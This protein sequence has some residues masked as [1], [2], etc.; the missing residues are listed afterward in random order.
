MSTKLPVVG[1]E[2]Y[3]EVAEDDGTSEAWSYTDG[4]QLQTNSNLTGTGT[5]GM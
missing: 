5:V 3:V 2:V 1:Y 4:E